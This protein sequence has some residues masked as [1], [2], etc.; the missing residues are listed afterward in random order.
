MNHLEN[1]T[2]PL[3]L[4]LNTFLNFFYYYYF[5]LLYLCSRLFGE[6]LLLVINIAEFNVLLSLKLT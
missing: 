5:S 4:S 3:F 2:D 6:F 1:D